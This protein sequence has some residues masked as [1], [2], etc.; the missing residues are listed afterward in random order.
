LEVWAYEAYINLFERLDFAALQ[1][2]YLDPLP[3]TCLN[4]LELLFQPSYASL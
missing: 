3:L 2:Y 1:A 4:F